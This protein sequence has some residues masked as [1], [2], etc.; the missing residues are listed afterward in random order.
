MEPYAQGIRM[1]VLGM[2]TNLVLAVIK[3]AAGVVGHSYALIA[4]GIE[5]TADVLSSLVVM[6][7]LKL[8][9]RPADDDHPYGHG[10]A[11]PMAGAIVACL[12]LLAAGWIAWSS[13]YEIRHP[14]RAPAWYTLLVLALVIVVKEAL[15]RKVIQTGSELGSTSVRGDGWHHRSDALTSGAAFLGISIALVGG[16]G[17][18]PADDWAALAACGIMGFNGI[19]LLQ[20]AIDDLMDHAVSPDQLTEVRALA[21]RVEGVVGIEKCRIRRVGLG[22]SMDIHVTVPAGAT[23]RRGHEIAHAVKDRLLA[24][25]HRITDVTVHIEPDDLGADR[26]AGDQAVD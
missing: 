11:E 9:A 26:A 19:R 5:S 3:I 6:G 1:A 17:Y 25:A 15:S 14:H 4:D 23:V 24:S 7:G 21:G 10:K 13:V 2:A 12:L 22:L 18:E 16:P 8:S 20:A